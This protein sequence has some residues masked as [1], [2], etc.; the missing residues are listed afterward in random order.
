[1][2]ISKSTFLE[3][4]NSYPGYQVSARDLEKIVQHYQEKYGIRLI[5]NGT[6]PTSEKLIK[7]RQENF[8]QQKQRFLQLKYARF[9]Q[10]FFHSP[11]VLSTT[12]PFAINK[13]DGVFKEY[14][15][16]IR[17]KIAPF[18]TSRGKVNSSLAPEELGELN[19]LCEELSCKPIFDKKI[20][21]FIEMNADFIGLTGE[22]SEQEIQEICAGL[23]GDEAVGYIFTGQRLTGKAHFEIYICLP[24]K[25][26]RPI[27][28]TFW[29]IDY[30]NLEGKLQL[31]SSSAEG[32]Y[33]TPDLLHLSRKGTMQQQLIPQADVMSCGTLAM[34]YA[35]ELL[36]DNA[37][38]LKE[39]TLSFTYY[40]D[41]GEK[42]C[43]FLPSPQVLRYS[44][45]SLYN[46]ALKAIVSKQNV[47]NPGVVEKDNKTYPFKTLEK[48]LEKSCEIAESKDDIEVQEENQR[49]MRFLP[50]FQEK[51]QQAYEEMLQKRQ[52]MQQQTGNKYL[53]YSTHRM[54][55][56]AQGHY[57]EEI[58][59][60]DIVDLETKT[61]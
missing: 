3:Q 11:D 60:D 47:Q 6:T 45:V 53:L 61:M 52:T 57:K 12:D 31:S 39:L 22:E 9:L 20:N 24:G 46:E 29:P 25:A 38:Q 43:F 19:R 26:I 4:E 42:E 49:I 17:N 55:N 35:K 21:E 54:S 14:Y 56:I 50:Q 41:R 48:I 23:T 36:K 51:W 34:M 1:M 7:D 27:L 18:L 33:F 59:G 16:E 32:N 15:Q 37:K 58:A 2:K 40:N 44:Q 30:F 13:H 8:E 10:I 28:Y 5:I